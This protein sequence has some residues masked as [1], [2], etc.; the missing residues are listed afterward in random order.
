MP[1]DILLFVIT[2][3][4]NKTIRQIET[5]MSET[6]SAAWALQNIIS[7]ISKVCK[8]LLPDQKNLEWLGTLPEEPPP[9]FAIRITITIANTTVDFVSCS[10]LLDVRRN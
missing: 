4:E 1:W 9:L 8:T 10:Q 3:I 7:N 6:S 5:R 2:E